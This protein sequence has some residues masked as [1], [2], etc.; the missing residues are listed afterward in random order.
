MLRPGRKTA[1]ERLT[2]FPLTKDRTLGGIVV[3][4][5]PM[6]REDI[7]VYLG[8]LERHISD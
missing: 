7:A 1:I 5:L 4:D 2:A 6:S 3:I 8:S